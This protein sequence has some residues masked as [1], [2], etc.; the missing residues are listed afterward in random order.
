MLQHLNNEEIDEDYTWELQKLGLISPHSGEDLCRVES[1]HLHTLTFG[2]YP[3]IILW[4]LHL[5]TLKILFC[6]PGSL[7]HSQRNKKREK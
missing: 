3:Y 4:F 5:H 1:V 2:I 6:I 7:F